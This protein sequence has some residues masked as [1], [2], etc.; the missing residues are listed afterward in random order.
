MAVSQILARYR[1]HQETDNLG[2]TTGFILTISSV[3]K[4]WSELPCAPSGIIEKV[5]RS[6]ATDLLQDLF[7][8][9]V[10]NC[11]DIAI[12]LAEKIQRPL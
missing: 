4:F 7:S 11:V 10:R 2:G 5:A 9:V 12:I 8:L 6:L 3:A 1:P